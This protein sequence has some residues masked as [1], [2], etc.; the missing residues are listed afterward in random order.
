MNSEGN[1]NEDLEAVFLIHCQI[2]MFMFML[3]L[4]LLYY[5]YKK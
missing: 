1:I 4:K 3:I 5:Y 2:S